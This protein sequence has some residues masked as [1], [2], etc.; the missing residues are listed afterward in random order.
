ML[1]QYELKKPSDR[2]GGGSAVDDLYIATLFERL[3]RDWNARVIDM[4]AVPGSSSGMKKPVWWSCAC[5]P[6][7]TSTG[8]KR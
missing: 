5:A 1:F 4:H 7:K 2:E 3:M 6:A 8:S